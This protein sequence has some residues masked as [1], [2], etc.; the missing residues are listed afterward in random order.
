[1][2]K[3]KERISKES[4][5]II[6]HNII[7]RAAYI[8]LVTIL[9]LIYALSYIIYLVFPKYINVI[10]IIALVLI[11]INVA[12]FYLMILHPVRTTARN[13]YWTKPINTT[14]NMLNT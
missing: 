2:Y 4:S 10:Y 7:K 11:L 1:M 8:N 5:E 13:N 14:I 3:Y 12:Y 9:Y 6:K